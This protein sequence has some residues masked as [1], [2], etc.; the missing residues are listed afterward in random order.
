MQRKKGLLVAPAFPAASFWS[1]KHVMKYAARKA[2]FPP[3]GLVTFAALMPEDWDLTLVDLNVESP[4]VGKLRR[5]IQ[6]ADAVFASAMS[7]QRD[8]LVEL[9]S[10]AAAGTDTPWVLGGPIASTYRDTI[11]EPHTEAEMV[12]H[13]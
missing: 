7:I 9:L 10:G 2:A 1:Y 3:L 13:K 5:M 4:S 6:E 8:S 11:L 12:L